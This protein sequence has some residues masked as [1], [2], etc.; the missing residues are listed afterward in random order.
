M[1]PPI[2]KTGMYPFLAMNQDFTPLSGDY[3]IQESFPLTLSSKRESLLLDNAP[4]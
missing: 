3:R 4:S 1:I 2:I